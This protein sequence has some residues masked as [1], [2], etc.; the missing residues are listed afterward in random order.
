MAI[1]PNITI[2]IV[3]YGFCR[4]YARR[5]YCVCGNKRSNVPSPL[6]LPPHGQHPL[7]LPTPR[8]GRAC[9]ARALSITTRYCFA[10]PSHPYIVG[11]SLDPS[12]ARRGRRPLQRWPETTPHPRT[13]LPAP[14]HPSTPPLGP[15]MPGPQ[16]P[17]RLPSIF[18]RSPIPPNHLTPQPAFHPPPP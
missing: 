2:I 11:R 7:T 13:F 8:R 17:H 6:R 18:H 4:G 14:A 10:T 1:P 5:F 16:P 12:A 3:V 15:G 9:P